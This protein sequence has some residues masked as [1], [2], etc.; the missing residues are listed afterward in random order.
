MRKKELN[1]TAIKDKWKKK[2]KQLEVRVLRTFL[3][4]RRQIITN[5]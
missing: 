1:Y 2:L 3:A 5:Q 4:K